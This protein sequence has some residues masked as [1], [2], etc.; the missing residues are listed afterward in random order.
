MVLLEVGPSTSFGSALDSAEHVPV[1]MP[2]LID[3]HAHVTLPSDR[4]GILEQLRASDAQLT[5]TAVRQATRHLHSGY[6]TIR[7]C[8]AR[9]TVA[10]E[11]R[12]AFEK[13][14]VADP[15]LLVCGRAITPSGGHLSCL[16]SAADTHH[17]IREQVRILGSQGADAIKLIASGG[18]TGGDPY[19]AS[20]TAAELAVG[21]RLPMR[22]AC[23]LS[24]IA[25][26]P[27]PS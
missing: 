3:T 16:G 6:T 22:W 19:R 2:G 20:Y 5:I 15:R 13:D 21:L 1:L 8:G 12:E 27:T 18:S 25:A 26:Q 23:R 10:F 14:V 17:E 24:R 7:D 11:V 4:L 9:G